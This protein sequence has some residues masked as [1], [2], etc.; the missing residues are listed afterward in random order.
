MKFMSNATYNQWL[1]DCHRLQVLVC[2]LDDTI[3]QDY[4]DAPGSWSGVNIDEE[5]FE[6]WR[7]D[8]GKNK[9][10]ADSEFQIKTKNQLKNKLYHLQKKISFTILV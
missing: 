2:S 7:S 3:T 1:C 10:V 8:S 9:L 5:I 4:L 6:L